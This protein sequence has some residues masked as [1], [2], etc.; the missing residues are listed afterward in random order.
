MV[1]NYDKFNE[2]LNKE[3][4]LPEYFLYNAFSTQ[5][6]RMFCLFKSIPNKYNSE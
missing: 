6:K 1:K 3:R 2:R 5:N 4:S